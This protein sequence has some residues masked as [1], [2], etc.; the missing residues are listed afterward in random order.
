MLKQGL[1]LCALMV[2]STG[3]ALL[4]PM[5]VPGGSLRLSELAKDGDAARRASIRLTLDGLEEDAAGQQAQARTSYEQALR[6]DGLNPYAYLALARHYADGPEHD[7]AESYLQQT[8]SLLISQD[9]LDD[10]VQAH[11][12]GLRGMVLWRQGYSSEASP[13][14]QHARRLAPAVWRDGR[15]DASELY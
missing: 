11:L 6:V 7:R 14:L 8:E 2:F 5:A 10:R 12:S 1:A 9:R 4:G 15:L 13:Y 3:C